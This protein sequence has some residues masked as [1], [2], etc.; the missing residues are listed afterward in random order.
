MKYSYNSHSVVS[1]DALYG[2][3]HVDFFEGIWSLAHC[4]VDSFA[5]IRGSKGSI[6]HVLPSVV[7]GDGN[8]ATA[9]RE[10]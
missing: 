1:R 3:F 2:Y 10:R 9:A 6:A 8:M 5:L 7:S 4:A